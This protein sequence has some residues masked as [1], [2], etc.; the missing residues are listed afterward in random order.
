M[1]SLCQNISMRLGF[2]PFSDLYTFTFGS[3]L[4]ALLSFLDTVMEVMYFY[5]VQTHNHLEVFENN[6]MFRKK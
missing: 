2:W 5:P 3:I 6:Q 4:A 1:F